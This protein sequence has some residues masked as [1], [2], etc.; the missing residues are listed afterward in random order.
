MRSLCGRAMWIMPTQS[1]SPTAARGGGAPPPPLADVS[2]QERPVQ[3]RVLVRPVREVV[4]VLGYGLEEVAGEEPG[5]GRIV[6]DDLL[7]L[8]AHGRTLRLV[9]LIHAVRDQHVSRIV[10]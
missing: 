1:F 2:G 4:N 8:P 10:G 7:R 6:H 5:P 3:A 9:S